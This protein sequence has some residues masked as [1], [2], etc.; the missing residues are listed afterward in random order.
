MSRKHC[1]PGCWLLLGGSAMSGARHKEGVADTEGRPRT[2]VARARVG[3]FLITVCGVRSHTVPY[4]F[5]CVRCDTWQVALG[6]TWA[7]VAA[8]PELLR[9]VR[10]Q[11]CVVAWG[12]ATSPC[13]E[14]IAVGERWLTSCRTAQGVIGLT[15]SRAQVEHQLLEP[16]PPHVVCGR[17]SWRLCVRPGTVW[18]HCISRCSSQSPPPLPFHSRS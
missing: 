8:D 18:M 7:V 9:Q 1:L 5:C 6:R 16:L 11:L 4:M 2:H 15:G 13:L 3:C 17:G 10:P 14:T 12:S